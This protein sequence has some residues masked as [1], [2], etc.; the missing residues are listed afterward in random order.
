MLLYSCKKTTNPLDVA[1]I[2]EYVYKGV[3]Y[4]EDLGFNDY[5][6]NVCKQVN[7][8]TSPI[9][10]TKE[11]DILELVDNFGEMLI[12]KENSKAFS[13]DE[14]IILLKHKNFKG[15]SNQYLKQFMQFVNLEE[16]VTI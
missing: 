10:R 15:Q 12:D 6:C 7:R 2:D 14:A 9:N 13:I 11:G 5:F 8:N 4:L 3:E 1:N 16:G